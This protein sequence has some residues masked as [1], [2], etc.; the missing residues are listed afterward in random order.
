MAVEST[1]TLT[2]WAL[3]RAACGRVCFT[4]QRFTLCSI[5]L[6]VPRFPACADSRNTDVSQADC[7]RVV[8]V[9]RAQDTL[10]GPSGVGTAVIVGQSLPFL[11]SFTFV[12]FVLNLSIVL[13]SYR[14]P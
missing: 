5:S 1:V 6:L 8:R 11:G 12:C 4:S 9:L 3:Q 2:V 7:R 10:G 13:K 14:N